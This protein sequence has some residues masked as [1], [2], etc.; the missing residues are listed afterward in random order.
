[1]IEILIYLF[2]YCNADDLLNKLY[3]S[4][5]SDYST[6]INNDLIKDNPCFYYSITNLNIFSLF[7][8]CIYIIKNSIQY[9][10]IN[11][12]AITLALL[13]TKY[14]L[15]TLL[16]INLTFTQFERSRNIMWLFATP[17]MLKMFCNINNL[18]FRH[19]NIQ[20]HTIPVIINIFIYPYKNTTVYYYFTGFSW[21]LLFMFM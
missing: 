2:L 5:F 11:N 20:Y 17:L 4:N 14:T 8:Y 13:Y 3:F 10:S 15:T 9:N 12:Y 21:I 6:I 7:L 16:N 1:M 19:I 18:K